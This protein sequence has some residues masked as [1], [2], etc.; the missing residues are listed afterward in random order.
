MIRLLL[1]EDD[2]ASRVFLAAVL[3]GLPATV[4]TAGTLAEALSGDVSQDLWLLDAN[5]PDGSGAELLAELRRRSPAATPALAHTADA[6]PAIRDRLLAAGF[7]GV[8]VKPLPAAE[9]LTGVR[10]VL[11]LAGAATGDAYANE[12]LP[13]WD[14]TAALAALNGHAG[15]VAALRRLFLDELPKQRAAIVASAAAR[16]AEALHRE[17]HRLKAS[18]GFV[19]AARLQAVATAFDH[20]LPDVSLLDEFDEI[21]RLTEQG[22]PG[23]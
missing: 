1:V 18:C 16:D 23:T 8:L 15:N 9:L 13:L 20:A 10:G 3:E 2:P 11:G 5:L 21:M 19:G 14:D 12:G 4:D 17:L 6:S 7:A 22:S